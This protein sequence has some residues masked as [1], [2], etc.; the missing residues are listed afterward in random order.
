VVGDRLPELAVRAGGAELARVTADARLGWLWRR[1][2]RNAFA[3]ADL[4]LRRRRSDGEE[5]LPHLSAHLFTPLWIP[6]S[7]S[8]VT[9]IN[10]EP[11]YRWWAEV[12]SEILVAVLAAL[13][14][15]SVTADERDEGGVLRRRNQPTSRVAGTTC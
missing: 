13:L 1:R 6:W 4:V 11:A 9:V 15:L 12:A 2:C 7:R 5:V 10:C 14:P 8:L 3:A